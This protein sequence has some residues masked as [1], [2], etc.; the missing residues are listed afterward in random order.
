MGNRIFGCDDC[1]LVCPGTSSRSAPTNRISARA[2]S[3]TSDVAG[4][5]RVDGG[6]IPAAHRRS[7]IRRSGHARWLRNIAIA[8]G[9]APTTPEVLAALRRARHRGRR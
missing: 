4:T 5:V 2:I 6:R 1:Q 7:A 9:N 3:W 8:L